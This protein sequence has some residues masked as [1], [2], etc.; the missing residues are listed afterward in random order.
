[1]FVNFTNNATASF[2][3]NN[4]TDITLDLQTNSVQI[5]CAVIQTCKQKTMLVAQNEYRLVTQNEYR[6]QQQQ[7]KTYCHVGYNGVNVC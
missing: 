3:R 6:F 7:Q 1:M 4:N 5:H 2:W